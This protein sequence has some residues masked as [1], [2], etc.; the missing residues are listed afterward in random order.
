MNNENDTLY[1]GKELEGLTAKKKEHKGIGSN[2]ALGTVVGALGGAGGAYAV[3]NYGNGED[4]VAGNDVTTACNKEESQKV[5]NAKQEIKEETTT[6]GSMVPVSEEKEES[7]VKP[8]E[9]EEERI[10]F[11]E[12]KVKI[13]DIEVKTDKD[14]KLMHLAT[15]EVDGHRAV[16]V[17]DGSGQVKGVV[18]D[19]NDNG[20]PDE[21]EYC[22]LSDKD[23]SLQDLADHK[24]EEVEV[25]VIAVKNDINIEGSTVDVAAIAVNDNPVVL[26]DVTQ[27]G[28]VDIAMADFNHNG[29]IEEGEAQ[30]VADAHIPMPTVNDVCGQDITMTSPTPDALPDYSDDSDI[31][32]YDI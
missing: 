21:N 27:N 28:E 18:D 30:D 26:V 7:E 17:E 14:G 31:T 23:V 10:F 4:I 5:D 32:F 25:K 9:A 24:Q 1:A 3:E 22:D 13:D 19:E 6:D 16:F 12:H 8:E 20:I 29:Q 11:D 2:V 15:G